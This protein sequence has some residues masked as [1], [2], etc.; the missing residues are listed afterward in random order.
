MVP[1]DCN[2]GIL[3]F[4][5][6][7]FVIGHLQNEYAPKIQSFFISLYGFFLLGYLHF[8]VQ[9]EYFCFQTYSLQTSEK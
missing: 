1:Y 8:V 9:I 4:M 6:T 2:L 5:P 3:F 7:H